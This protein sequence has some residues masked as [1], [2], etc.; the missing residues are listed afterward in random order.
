[1]L[2]QSVS[3]HVDQSSYFYWFKI[4]WSCAEVLY[5]LGLC[6]SITEADAIRISMHSQRNIEDTY[7]AASDAMRY[8]SP[9]L[10]CSAIRFN[11]MRFDA[12]RCN[13]KNMIAFISLVQ[14]DSKSWIKLCVFWLLTPRGLFHKTSLPNRPGLFQLV[15]LAVKLFGSIKQI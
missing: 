2:S 15:W 4:W 10:R 13:W 6:I 8:D 3:C 12:I 5:I 9:L 14:T 7:E 1:M 11:T